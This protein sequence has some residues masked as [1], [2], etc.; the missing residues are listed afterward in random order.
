[1]RQQHREI[2]LV[3]LTAAATAILFVECQKTLRQ[4]RREMKNE[5]Q[6]K[7]NRFQKV[8]ANPG[9][10]ERGSTS[11]ASPRI[12]GKRKSSASRYDPRENGALCDE[13]PRNSRKPVPPEGKPGAQWIWLGQDPGQTEERLGRPFVGATGILLSRIWE[14]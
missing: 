13:C 7:T 11:A 14:G 10:N 12:L 9:Q 1:M 2:A 6:D 8:E 3:V 5:A 4:E